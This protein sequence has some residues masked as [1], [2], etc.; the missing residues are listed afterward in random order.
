MGAGGD[1]GG[2]CEGGGGYSKWISKEWKDMVGN[3]ETKKEKEK[4][5]HI[6]IKYD[7]TKSER[8]I[9]MLYTDRHEMYHAF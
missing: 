4:R 5:R 1:C 2:V 9:I 6:S 3:M 7:L 8:F